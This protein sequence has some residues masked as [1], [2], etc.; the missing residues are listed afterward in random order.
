MKF[1]LRRQIETVGLG[2]TF[3]E[4]SESGANQGS[5]MV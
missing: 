2:N 5:E 3:I 4:R 1:G